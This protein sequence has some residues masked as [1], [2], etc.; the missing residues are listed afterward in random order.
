M[1]TGGAGND[2]CLN[3]AAGFEVRMDEHTSA[4]ALHDSLTTVSSCGRALMVGGQICRLHEGMTLHVQTNSKRNE[5]P[6]KHSNA[7]I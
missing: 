1:R 5:K 7:V 2:C 3:T 6:V 4:S